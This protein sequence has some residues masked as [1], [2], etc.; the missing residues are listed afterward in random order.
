VR[1]HG[2]SAVS[3]PLPQ[4]CVHSE[5]LLACRMAPHRR[6]PA[7]RPKRSLL[8]LPD[9]WMLLML[10]GGLLS[11]ADKRALMATC[12]SVFALVLGSLPACTLNLEVSAGNHLSCCVYLL[13]GAGSA[14][15]GHCAHL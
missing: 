4:S 5:P 10:K 9:A 6:A 14:A 7:L 11:R 13:C 15:G 12:R 2:T 3:T 8:E 1:W